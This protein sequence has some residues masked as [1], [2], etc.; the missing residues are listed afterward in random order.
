MMPDPDHIRP[1]MCE[2]LAVHLRRLALTLPLTFAFAL[3]CDKGEPKKDPAAEEKAKKD[4]EE[5]AAKE[6]RQAA[7]EAKAAEEKK[8]QE[9]IAAKIQE[10]TAIPEGTK[11]PKKIADACKQY[12]DAQSSFMKKFYPEVGP[13]ALATQL[14]MLQKQCLESN[15][16]EVTMCQKFALD[17]TTEEL[18]SLINEYL[19]ICITKYGEAPP[20]PPPAG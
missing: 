18:K 2:A 20:A 6:R 19:P 9:A 8:A 14:G 11:L 10:I 16:I 1:T 7:R 15:D 4:E 5:K 3:A 17:G 12:A 13:D